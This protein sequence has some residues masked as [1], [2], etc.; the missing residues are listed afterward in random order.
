MGDVGFSTPAILL[1]G[2]E[3]YSIRLLFYSDSCDLYKLLRMPHHE[4]AD[5]CYQMHGRAVD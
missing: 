4:K 1:T 5:R 2:V 3:K